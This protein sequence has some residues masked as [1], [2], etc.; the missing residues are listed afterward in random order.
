[1]MDMYQHDGATMFRFVLRGELAGEAVED[2]EQAWRTAQSVARE[3]QLEQLARELL[4]ANG[5]KVTT[6]EG[7]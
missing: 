1:M 7:L 4:K 3:K 2:L 6:E 5:I